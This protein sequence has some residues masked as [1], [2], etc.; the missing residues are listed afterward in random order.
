MK[1]VPDSNVFAPSTVVGSIAFA[2]FE[3]DDNLLIVAPE[4]LAGW[5]SPAFAKIAA[6]I[7]DYLQ[8]FEYFLPVIALA[9]G[10]SA[11]PGDM[12]KL[13]VVAVAVA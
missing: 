3:P 13:V 5:E 9:V 2:E 10:G 4:H 1:H 11:F 7:E 12:L 6:V 8:H